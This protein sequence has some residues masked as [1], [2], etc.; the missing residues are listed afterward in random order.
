M[1]NEHKE[2]LLNKN[3]EELINAEIKI[4]TNKS[5]EKIFLEWSNINYSITS[6]YKNKNKNKVQQKNSESREIENNGNNQNSDELNSVG[7]IDQNKKIILQNIEGYALPNE[8]LA[9]MGPSGS[10]KTSLL[11]IIACRQLPTDKDHLITRVVKANNIP[12]DLSNFG[13]ICAYIM[14]EDILIDTLTPRESL[15]FCAKLKLHKS[16]QE[17]NKRVDKLIFQFGLEKCA[18]SRVGSVNSKGISGGERKRTSIAYEL[19]SDPPIVIIDEPTTGMDSF[20]SLVIIKYL[21]GLAKTGKTI[22]N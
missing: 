10:G 4:K 21:K 16:E 15:T 9:I 14:Q 2:A 13:Q 3:T 20:T 1:K 17:I 18:N 5:K 8:L 22:S 6:N 19:I 11:N 7:E 12:V